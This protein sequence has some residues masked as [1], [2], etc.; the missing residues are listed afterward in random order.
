MNAFKNAG[1]SVKF[2]QIGNEINDGFL[3]PVGKPSQSGFNNLSQLLHSASS[4]VRTA[5]PSSRIMIH[6]ANGWKYD[7]INWFF[8]NV[9]YQGAFSTSD[10]DV[11]GFSMYPFYG[12]SATLSSLKTSLTNVV[13]WFNKVGSKMN[14]NVLTK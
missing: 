12:T 1:L 9:F 6:L 3:W 10:F 11:F 13:N 14:A 7:T 8:S 2:V 4:A 5:S